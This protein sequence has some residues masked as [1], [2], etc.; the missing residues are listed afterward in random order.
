MLRFHTAMCNR[1]EDFGIEPSVAGQLFGIH[2]IA[3]TDIPNNGVK[4]RY[5]RNQDL[6]AILPELLADPNR[7][8]SRFHRDA[9]LRYAP[10]V[11]FSRDLATVRKPPSSTISASSSRMQ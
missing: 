5:V 9:C 2:L 6:V 4:F 8:R 7:M 10:E 3:L 1:S 11:C